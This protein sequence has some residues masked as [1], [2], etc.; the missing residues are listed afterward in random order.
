[1]KKPQINLNPLEKIAISLPTQKDYDEVMRVIECG[2]WEEVDGDDFPTETNFWKNSETC[3][4]AGTNSITHEWGDLEYGTK[5]SFEKAG[6]KVI[7]KQEFYD[8][9]VVGLETRNWIKGYFTWL[10]NQ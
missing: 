1:M 3:I 5:K 2:R 10:S 6:Y 8:T 7:S 4:S 9:E